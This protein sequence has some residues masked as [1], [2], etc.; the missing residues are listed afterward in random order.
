MDISRVAA[1]A[2]IHSQ[3]VAQKEH[4]AEIKPVA[5]ELSEKQL[6]IK[7]Q[8]AQIK[9]DN[10]LFGAL[11]TLE[12]SLG[13]IGGI[14]ASAKNGEIDQ[15]TA[16]ETIAGKIALTNYK[17]E[18]LF[19]HYPLEDGSTIDI[20]ERLE[21]PD[22]F[23]DFAVVLEAVSKETAQ[24]LSAVKA[25]VLSGTQKMGES[26][27]ASYEKSGVNTINPSNIFA[28]TNANYLKEQFSHLM[29]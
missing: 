4:T 29:R 17:N 15:E 25:R 2:F 1:S 23:D 24:T 13:V 7:N 28:S 10:D 20:S 18:N 27:Q 5:T 22:S 19:K 21:A 14:I 3:A 8:S 12:R 16:S 26:A 6:E 9:S 11:K